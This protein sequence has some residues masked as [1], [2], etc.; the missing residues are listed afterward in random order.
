VL[1]LLVLGQHAEEGVAQQ[2]VSIVLELGN[3]TQ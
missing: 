3:P 2:A 1:R